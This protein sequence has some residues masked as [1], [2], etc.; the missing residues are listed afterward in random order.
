MAVMAERPY[1]GANFL[2]T[3][4]DA[5]SRALTA[6]FSEVVFPPFV[7]DRGRAAD[8]VRPSRDNA[9][10]LA[11]ARLVLRRG[12][13]G[14]LDLYAWWDEAR[15]AKAP[16]TRCVTVEL[17]ADDQRTVVL[18]WRFHEAYP[19]SLSYSPLRAAEGG[20]VIESVE[21]AFARVEMG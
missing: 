6:G 4:G 10:P 19:V 13:I 14:S 8:A 1:S 15:G 12:A 21:L 5:D 2:V 9:S 20:F 18:T 11:P 3:I 16:P 7:L 17:L